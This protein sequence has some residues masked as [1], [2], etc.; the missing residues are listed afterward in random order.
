MDRSTVERTFTCSRGKGGQNV[1]RRSTC[2]VLKHIPSGIIVR[3]EE[4]R[5]QQ[6][7]EELGWL[8]LEEKLKGIYDNQVYEDGKK[9]RFDQIGFSSRSDKRRTYRIKDDVVIDHITGK[10]CTWKEFNKG[11]IELLK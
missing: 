2:V 7:N 3:S 6:K 1:N 11:K 5:N 4:T 8:R 10:S 9:D